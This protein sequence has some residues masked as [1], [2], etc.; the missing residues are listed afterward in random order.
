MAPGGIATESRETGYMYSTFRGI[1]LGIAK[2]TRQVL[3][4]SGTLRYHG[5]ML[6]FLE[7]NFTADWRLA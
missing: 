5:H 6:E 3:R 2:T 7:N 4:P 1:A